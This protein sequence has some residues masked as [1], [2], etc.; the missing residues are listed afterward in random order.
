M[1][2]VQYYSVFVSFPG[3][4]AAPRLET[5]NKKLV[6]AAVILDEIDQ[7]LPDANCAQLSSMRLR[8]RATS[9]MLQGSSLAAPS[10]RSPRWL[11]VL[12]HVHAIS[13]L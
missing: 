8:A 2:E 3:R 5:Y 1:G 10:R 6:E 9:K 11:Q 13:N 4:Y 7:D 12:I